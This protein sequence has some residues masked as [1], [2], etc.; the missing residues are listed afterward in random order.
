MTA[1]TA[2]G[3]RLVWAGAGEARRASIVAPPLPA[4]AEVIVRL[5]TA[6][7]V[8]HAHV[9]KSLYT[10]HRAPERERIGRALGCY[11]RT[12][13][14]REEFRHAMKSLTAA[15]YSEHSVLAD[16]DGRRGQAAGTLLVFSVCIRE[17]T[18]RRGP[19]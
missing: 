15:T 2:Y 12:H 11:A 5:R 13:R 6:A 19:P 18:S 7:E 4:R 17:A 8:Q 1:W 10:T 3:E 14:A 16:S 9:V